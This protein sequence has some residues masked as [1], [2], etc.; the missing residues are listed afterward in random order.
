MFR[1]LL[2]WTL[3]AAA[4][5]AAVAIV[6]RLRASLPGMEPPLPEDH[7]AGLLAATA[8]N[9]PDQQGT[10]EE[11]G[12][13]IPGGQVPD[14]LPASVPCPGALVIYSS[15]I[16]RVDDCTD[17]QGPAAGDNPVARTASAVAQAVAAR[18]PCAAGCEKRVTEVW[19]GWECGN[20]PVTAVVAVELKITCAVSA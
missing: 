20:T 12:L 8:P 11:P 16:E 17:Y 10:Y 13:V 18:I 15:Y 7:K 14:V 3:I 19:R 4:A 5:G 9:F 6:R 1:R 2:R